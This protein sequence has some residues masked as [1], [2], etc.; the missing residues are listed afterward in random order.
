V[1]VK[2]IAVAFLALLACPIV[3]PGIHMVGNAFMLLAE[4]EYSVPQ[5]SSI[6]TFDCTRISEGGNTSY[7][8]F[9][10]DWT[11]YYAAC[12]QAA[13]GFAACTGDFESYPKVAAESCGGFNAHDARTWCAQ[14]R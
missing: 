11:H 7:C 2:R 12:G 8:D 1:L 4:P 9:G 5:A 13:A 3:L 6:V 14:R 10:K